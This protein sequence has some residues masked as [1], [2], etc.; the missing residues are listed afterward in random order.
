MT[1][2]PE[3]MQAGQVIA[4]RFRLDRAVGGDGSTLWHAVDDVLAL[5]V[6]LRIIDPQPAARADAFLYAARRVSVL[7]DPGLVRMYDAVA[8]DGLV[9]SVSEWVDGTTLE[10]LVRAEG[11]LTASVAASTVCAVAA[12]L[13]TASARGLHHGHL[14][15]ANVLLRADRQVKVTDLGTAAALADPVPAPPASG[16]DVPP[17]NTDPDA[18]AALAR[19]AARADACALGRLLYFTLTGCWP[20]PDRPDLPPARVVDGRVCRPR[21]VRAGVPAGLDRL[22]RDLLAGPADALAS[23]GRVVA[24]LVD[25]AGRGGSGTTG[26]L[27]V[28]RADPPRP[29]RR[30]GGRLLGIAGALGGVV[31]VGGT[32]Y[33]A[34]MSPGTGTRSAG[35]F[36]A[37]RDH[38]AR[39]TAAAAVRSAV[40]VVSA[41]TLDPYG[42]GNENDDHV[43]RALDGNPDDAWSTDTYYGNPA[44]GGLK[45][46]VGLLLDLGRPVEVRRLTLGMSVPGATLDLR[47]GDDPATTPDAYSVVASTTEAGRT[48]TFAPSGTSAH[49][50]WVV[51]ITRLPSVGGDHYRTGI[52]TIAIEK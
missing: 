50:Y 31:A 41:Y 38:G 51:W 4:G 5:P 33:L 43:P 36:P 15:P 27:P 17:L 13:A 25:L 12:A 24:A 18:Q 14:H 52:A 49:R 21:Q 29:V 8:R 32:G 9:F 46:G 10:E 42:D 26:E 2:P 19:A 7:T 20:G 34:G 47:A 30:R 45:P 37:L 3:V 1:A 28:T 44:F 35:Q 40:P 22:T 6:A 48:V 39:P 23:P 16:V 11:P